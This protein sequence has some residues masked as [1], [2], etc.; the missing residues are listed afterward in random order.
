MRIRTAQGQV[1]AIQKI[2]QAIASTKSDPVIYLTA[3]RYIDKLGEIVS[4]K[5]N[6]EEKY[7]PES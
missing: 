1:E 6:T 3:V 2:T 5:D 7:P 4:G